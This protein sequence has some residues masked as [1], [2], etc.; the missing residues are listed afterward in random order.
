MDNPQG[1]KVFK[2]LNEAKSLSDDQRDIYFTIAN[3]IVEVRQ[4]MNENHTFITRDIENFKMTISS[5]IH[6]LENTQNIRF[7]KV[8]TGFEKVNAEFEKV[9]KEIAT[10]ST[11]TIKWCVG[12]M[13]V[14]T[15]GTIG[16]VVTA[17]LS[18]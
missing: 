13:I 15:L 10:A 1:T 11:N 6:A 14:C 9:R 17:I 8:N 2:M 16:A 18:K 7:E 3:E 5:E 4:T 12:A